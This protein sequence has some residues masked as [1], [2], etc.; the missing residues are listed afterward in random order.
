[1]AWKD[2][3]SQAFFPRE[4]NK[5]EEAWRECVSPNQMSAAEYAR[6]S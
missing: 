5:S 6:L 4:R 2:R 3:L 1:M